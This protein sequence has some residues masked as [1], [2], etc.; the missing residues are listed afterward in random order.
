MKFDKKPTEKEIN[1]LKELGEIIYHYLSESGL[2]TYEAFLMLP[3]Q[4]TQEYIF[5]QIGTD[6]FI[7][8]V[9]STKEEVVLWCNPLTAK[10]FMGMVGAY[11]DFFQKAS[12]VSFNQ[13][14]D[15]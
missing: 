14:K 2:G 8:A 1:A 7:N 12:P 15:S 5:K 3:T 10:S 13:P 9:D 4:Q 6:K 11:S